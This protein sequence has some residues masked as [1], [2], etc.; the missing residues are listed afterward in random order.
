MRCMFLLLMYFSIF[1]SFTFISPFLVIFLSL[2]HSLLSLHFRERELWLLS[3]LL[4]VL[5]SLRAQR[6]GC[7][8]LML[9]EI[10]RWD[11]LIMHLQL[12]LEMMAECMTSLIDTQLKFC[13]QG[14]GL[15][16]LL[17]LKL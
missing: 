7:S 1:V 17:Y 6:R 12:T 14:Y 8:L 3:G 10:L 16:F 13:N 15:N 4:S 2:Y 11:R 9:G 5:E